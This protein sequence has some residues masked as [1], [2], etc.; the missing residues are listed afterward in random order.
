M[1]KEHPILMSTPLIQ[2]TMSGVKTQ[3][4]RKNNLGTF[5]QNPT[6]WK[7]ERLLVNDKGELHAFFSPVGPASK[8]GWYSAKCPYGNIG[9]ILWVRETWVQWEY[10]TKKPFSYAYKADGF[11][12]I[13][14]GA[15][16]KETP[17]KLHDIESVAKWSQSIFMPKD[18]C[19]LRLEIVDVEIQKLGDITRAEAA[20]EGMCFPADAVKPSWHRNHKWPEE[21]FAAGWEAINGSYNPL[22]YV[23]VITFKRIA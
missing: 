3:T 6:D 5:N 15:W 18:A 10:P 11:K 20:K 2:P 17:N 23:W 4:R 9:D 8:T 13:K 22:I 12:K 1:T 14:G 7:F 21:N 19:R 16:E